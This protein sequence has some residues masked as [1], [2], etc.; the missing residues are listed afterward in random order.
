LQTSLLDEALKWIAD[1]IKENSTLLTINISNDYIGDK[2]GKYFA[3]AIKVNYTLQTIFLMNGSI[4]DEGAKCIAEALKENHTLQRIF[5]DDNYIG[6]K[7]DS[8][9]S[10]LLRENRLRMERYKESNF[11]K[12]ICAFN[13]YRKDSIR[14]RFDKMILRFLYYPILGLPVSDHYIPVQINQSKEDEENHNC[15]VL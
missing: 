12:F 3:E 7:L 10:D 9:I 2:G 8:Q 1:V 15:T 13:E 6:K 5:L 11:L 14:L 4:G